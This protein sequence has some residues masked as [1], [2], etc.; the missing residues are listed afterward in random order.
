MKILYS[1][2]DIEKPNQIVEFLSNLSDWNVTI[3]D[4]KGQTLTYCST[5]FF[6]VLVID[7]TIEA[8]QWLETI[9]TIRDRQIFTP[10]LVIAKDSEPQNRIAGLE[11][12]ADMCI[13]KPFSEKEM[14]LRIR[15]LKRRNTNY[16]SPTITFEEI[17]LN[18][19]DGKICYEKTSLSVNPI[20][21]EIF[22]LLTRATAPI[23][24]KK[25][26][27]KTNEPEDKILFFAQC[28]QKKIGLLNSPIRLEIK[29]SKCKLIKKQN[30]KDN[31]DGP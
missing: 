21:I 28:L 24:I 26:S 1:V 4:S 12:G 23:H 13:V 22:R 11:E 17:T 2:D 6:D 25:L 10:I 20:E 9:K 15:T 19:P 31:S 27:E 14:L 18:R 3:S 7:S 29:N 30:N 16:Q 5:Q 8:T